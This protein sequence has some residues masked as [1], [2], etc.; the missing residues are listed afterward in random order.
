[1]QNVGSVHKRA[2]RNPLCFSVINYSEQLSSLIVRIVKYILQQVLRILIP[3]Q[4]LG[5]LLSPFL[6]IWITMAF[7]HSLG[8]NVFIH[9]V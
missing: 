8:I 2:F 3:L 1:M 7:L 5:S 4:F 6:N 9:I